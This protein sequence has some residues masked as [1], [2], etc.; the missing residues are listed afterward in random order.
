LAIYILNLDHYRVREL[1]ESGSCGGGGQSCGNLGVRELNESGSCGG[2]G[3]SFGRNYVGRQTVY[4]VAQQMQAIWKAP[5]DNINQLT[6]EVCHQTIIHKRG[7]ASSF[8]R[9]LVRHRVTT[10]I[11]ST[12]S[13]ASKVSNLDPGSIPSNVEMTVPAICPAPRGC[14]T[15]L[16]RRNE[17][18]SPRNP[19]STSGKFS[20]EKAS[21][22]QG[23]GHSESLKARFGYACF[24]CRETRHW[25]A[26][27]NSFWDD[28]LDV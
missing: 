16:Q 11:Q 28:L 4:P 21:F 27:C 10:I 7:L 14:Y 8:L 9:R 19:T 18:Q 13:K 15:P 22:Y 12:L 5:Q 6:A 24:Y 23:K 2:G 25:Y 26:D 17:E 20:V 1:N 3:Q